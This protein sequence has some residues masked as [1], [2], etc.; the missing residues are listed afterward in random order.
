[1][2]IY[3]AHG[4]RWPRD[5]FTGIRVHA[6]INNLEECSVEYIQ[7][8]SSRASL[9]MSFRKNY[10]D[11]M[12]ELEKA[13]RRIDFLEQYDP[14]DDDPKTAV[15]QP[16]AF[17]CDRVAMIA[18]GANAEYYSSKLMQNKQPK[19]GRQVKERAKT[20]PMSLAAPYNS[21]ANITAL[22]ANMENVIAEG[23]GFST[24]QWE[25]LADLRDKLAE[26]EKIGWWCVYNGD[27]ERSFE[28]EEEEAEEEDM[29]AAKEEKKPVVSP[30]GGRQPPPIPPPKERGPYPPLQNVAMPAAMPVREKHVELLHQG[31]PTPAVTKKVELSPVEPLSQKESAKTVG[32]RKKLFGKKSQ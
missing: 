5:G 25:A 31:R 18:G 22:S 14:D 17:V 29:A 2:P 28:D 16:Y 12:V 21:P 13:G 1:M 9:L 3:F 11:T 27:P 30:T 24:E 10:S 4:F 19:S 26:G 23:S 6:I 8:D 15:S 20:Q 7:N 32:L